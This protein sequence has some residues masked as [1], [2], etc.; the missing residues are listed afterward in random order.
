MKQLPFLNGDEIFAE[1]TIQYETA[2]N[3]MLALDRG[4]VPEIVESGDPDYF[5]KQLEMR[6]YKADF[7]FLPFQIQNNYQQQIDAYKE[8]YNTKL[9]EVQRAKD[10]FI[11]ADGPMVPIEGMYETVMG[12][13]GQ[14]KQQRVQIY[15]SSLQWLIEQLKAQKIAFGQI[16]T[17]PLGQQAALAETYNQGTEMPGG[18]F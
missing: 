5:F 7:R 16:E 11:P 1:Y 13:N 6:K 14:A 12:S 17:L 8:L 2:R 10:G 18:Q 4:E 3:I 9:M 15:Q